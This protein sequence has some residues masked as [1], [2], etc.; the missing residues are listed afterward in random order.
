MPRKK[1]G[2]PKEKPPKELT[3]AAHLPKDPAAL[4]A[5]CTAGSSYIYNTPA[6]FPTPN[7]PASQVNAALAALSSALTSAPGGSDAQKQAVRAAAKKVRGLWGLLV[8]YVESVLRT[9]NAAD[10]PTILASCLMYVSN[11]GNR[12]PKA[13][14][15]A[16]HTG[17]SGSVKLIA[18][19][20]ADALTYDWQWSLDQQNWSTSRSGESQ[21]VISGLIPG[22]QYWFRVTAFLRGNTTTDPIGPVS[23]FVV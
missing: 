4:L 3:L 8:P 10:V 17:T 13:P 2:V 23:L 7:P 20:I 19:A 14:L 1:S 15:A 12:N 16:E 6:T 21:T 9:Q 18:L 5:H 11:I 22:K